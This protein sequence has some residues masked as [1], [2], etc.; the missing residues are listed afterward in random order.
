MP[1]DPEIQKAIADT[2]KEQL[3]SVFGEAVKPLTEQ[4][5][6]QQHDN[7]KLSE[8]FTTLSNSIPGL[9]DERLKDI[10]PSLDFISEVKKEYE[11][12]QNDT[13]GDNSDSDKLREAILAEIKKDYESKLTALQTQL[14]ERDKETKALREADRQTKMRTDVLNTMRGLGTVRPNTEED[15]LTLLEKRGLLVEE[16]DRLFVKGVDKFGDATKA[17]FKDILPKM[18][19][20]DFAHFAVP[21]GGTGTDGAPGNRATPSQYNFEGMSA[22]DI[23]NQYGTDEVAQKALVSELEKQ[24]GKPS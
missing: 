12:E 19:E 7:K 20:T 16:G 21:R 4:L 6:K 10:K 3:T 13:A 11:A 15:L 18:L 2:V 8:A 17:E 9:L 14:D 5:E 24:Y 22:Q 1:L 23:Y